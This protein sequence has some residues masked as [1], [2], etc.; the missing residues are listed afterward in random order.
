VNNLF[1]I[2]AA[3]LVLLLSSCTK[4]EVVE[5]H[6]NFV[7]TG[8]QPPD[9]SG[10]TTLQ[11]Q[12]YVNRLYV[13]LVG[14]QPSFE[15]LEEKVAFLQENDLSDDSRETLIDELMSTDEYYVNFFNYTSIQFLSGVSQAQIDEQI[16][17]YTFVIQ[18]AYDVGDLL[19]AQYLEY[20]LLKLQ[21]LDNAALDLQSNA[22][23]INDYYKRFCDNLIY[24]EIN[25]GSENF[26]ISCFENLFG[27]YPTLEELQ[28]GVQ[29][30]DGAPS[31]FLLQSGDSKND[32][33]NIVVNDEEFYVGRVVEQF[34]SLLLR[35][36]TQIEEQQY[37]EIMLEAETLKALQKSITKSDEYAGF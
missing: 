32:F 2:S 16:E 34:Q 33:L 1:R 12:S 14:E 4:T 27:R 30:V 23:N 31:I 17:L 10:V 28:G 37:T 21:Q 20:E 13:D 18:Q 11:V 36:P 7:V 6:E 29:M 5:V 35:N 26:V 22:I 8:N 25:M 3:L 24:D 19:V 15:Q 9:Y